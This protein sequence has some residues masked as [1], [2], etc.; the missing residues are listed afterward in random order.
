M[1][2]ENTNKL[3]STEIDKRQFSFS[4]KWTCID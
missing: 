2:Q 4:P 1:D 3:L